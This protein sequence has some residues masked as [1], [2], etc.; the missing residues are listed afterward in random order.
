M[1]HLKFSDLF[2]DVSD[3]DNIANSVPDTNGAYFVP[4]FSGLQVKF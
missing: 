2:E 3:T 1:S 4:A